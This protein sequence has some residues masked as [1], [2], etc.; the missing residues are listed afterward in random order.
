M[1]E[2]CTALDLLRKSLSFLVWAMANMHILKNRA[3]RSGACEPKMAHHEV[4]FGPPGDN[5]VHAVLF[6]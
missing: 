4:Q 2:F 6:K 1:A 3:A 5:I